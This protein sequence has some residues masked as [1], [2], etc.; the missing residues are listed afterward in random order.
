VPPAAKV[1]D[2]MTG[3]DAVYLDDIA[4]VVVVVAND[5]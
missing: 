4:V 2:G 5:G 1:I 3:V